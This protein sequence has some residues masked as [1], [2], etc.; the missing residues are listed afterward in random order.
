MKEPRE[1]ISTKC[2]EPPTSV[3]NNSNY[4][5]KNHAASPMPLS[6]EGDPS[7]STTTTTS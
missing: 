4:H 3:T 7:T 6:I 2:S 1:Q 5:N